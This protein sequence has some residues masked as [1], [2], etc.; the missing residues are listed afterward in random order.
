MT[1]V[2]TDEAVIR[3][4]ASMPEVETL[5]L[6]NGKTYTQDIIDSYPKESEEYQ[7][8]SKWV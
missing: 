7:R 5:N 1:N 8:L 4:L 3:L 6:S 2:E